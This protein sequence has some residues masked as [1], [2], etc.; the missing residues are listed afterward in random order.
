MLVKRISQDY[1]S[2]IIARAQSDTSRVKRNYYEVFDPTNCLLNCR[3]GLDLEQNPDF[4]KTNEG[5]TSREGRKNVRS[6][7]RECVQDVL[8]SHK[9]W[10]SAVEIGTSIEKGCGACNVFREILK[11]LFPGNQHGL[12]AAYSYSIT[13]RFALK[14]RLIGIDESVETIQL[15]RPRGSWIH[16][17]SEATK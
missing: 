4:V 3:E 7:R 8:R 12:S 11:E 10:F 9:E 1:A 2:E 6:I 14:R 13:H 15:F 17:G 16:R 5:V